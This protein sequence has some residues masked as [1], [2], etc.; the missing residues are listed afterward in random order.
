MGAAA[1]AF[2]GGVDSGLV[3]AMAHRAFPKDC[4][5]LTV[6]FRSLPT[7]ER[8]AIK[9]FCQK[10]NIRH[11]FIEVDEL[12]IPGF[13]D[14]QPDRCYH[15]KHFLFSQMQS[16]A[17]DAGLTLVD[18]SNV[19]DRQGYRPGLRALRELNVV[20]PLAECDLDK[21]AVRRLA[22]ALALPMADKASKPCLATR[23]PYG[24]QLTHQKLN[25][26][27]RAEELLE[28][29]GFTNFRVR[30]H[31]KSARIEVADDD[32]LRFANS[33][34]RQNIVD[35]FRGFGF[36]YIS[37]DLE[38]FQSGSM[39][40]MPPGP[41]KKAAHWLACGKSPP[42]TTNTLPVKL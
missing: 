11:R 14:N 18:G 39:D 35:R 24:E 22:Q 4:L 10:S 19:D 31:D 13:A 34:L 12:L 17:D 25:R 5:A 29:L 21:N 8:Q 27:A 41:V 15:C 38:G 36:V 40:R 7:A 30:S 6:A 2:S 3:L 1:V 9:D 26:V 28:G 16:I 32:W 33:G 20:S 37:L 23:F 42:T